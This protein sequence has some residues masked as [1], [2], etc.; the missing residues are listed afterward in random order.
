MLLLHT[1]FIAS[2][3]ILL[4]TSCSSELVE[5]VREIDEKQYQL[6][7]GYQ[8]QGREDEALSAFLRVIDTRRDS[9]ESHF[10]AG[11]IYLKKM[12]DPISAIYHFKCYIQLKP[13]SNQI[14]QVEQ[15][16]ET[17]QKEFVRQLPASPYEGQ[18]KGIDLLDLV[19]GLKKENEF[20]K[21]ESVAAKRR[22]EQLEVILGGTR[23]TST[24]MPVN[25]DSL[26]SNQ[27]T[28]TVDQSSSLSADLPLD[29]AA[30]PRAYTVQSGD[31]LSSISRKFYGTTSRWND[32]YQA[33]RDRM[34]SENALRVG[35]DIR[36]P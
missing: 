1:C 28:S 31:S 32:I 23:L 19:D 29:P 14:A 3:I 6:A 25:S 17:A 21:R 12:K 15:L 10:E 7:K 2:L 9:P 22:V 36:I 33:N 35:Q 13:D 4:V 20:L 5:I 27:I 8:A 11:Y 34:S 24:D 26:A 18:L 30:V 16:I